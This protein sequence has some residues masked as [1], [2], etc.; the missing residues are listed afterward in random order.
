MPPADPAASPPGAAGSLLREEPGRLLL[1]VRVTP[2]AGREAIALDSG[3]LRV[4]LAAAPV[5]GAANVALLTLLARRLRVPRRTVTL[6]R[7]ASS[8]VKVIAVADLS[9]GDFWAR[10][11]S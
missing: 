4:R 1:T 8:R 7:G 10:L 5:D 2:R 9:A 3:A 11:G 6:V